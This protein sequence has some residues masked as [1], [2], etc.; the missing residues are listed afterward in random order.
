KIYHAIDSYCVNNADEVWS[1]SSRIVEIRKAMGLRDEKNIF[2]PNV[3]PVEYDK[4]KGGVRDKYMMVTAGI[5]DRQLDFMGVVDTLVTLNDR[6]PDLRFTVIGNGPE[7]ENI[8][9]Y[10]R[11]RG[12]EDKMI[13]TGRLALEEALERTSRA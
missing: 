1:V 7:E 2:V 6:Y 10:A 4:F 9:K 12:V 13:F 11:E 3:P 8:K 5:I